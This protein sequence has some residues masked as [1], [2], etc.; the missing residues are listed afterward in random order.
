M[1]V[2]FDPD[3]IDNLDEGV[4]AGVSRKQ[5]A[6]LQEKLLATLDDLEADEPD[7]NTEEDAYDEWDRR[8]RIL[9]NL[10]DAIDI[11]LEEN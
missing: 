8:I 6:D 2:P 7:I 9:Q 11:Q 4:L 3:E 10:I 5:M 1:A